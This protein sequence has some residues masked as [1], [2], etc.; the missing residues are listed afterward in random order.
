MIEKPTPGGLLDLQ[1]I[2]RW[3]VVIGLSVWAGV[4][5]FVRKLNDGQSRPFNF[6]E[7]IGEITVSGFT[8][9]LTAY[10][11]AAVG[12]HGPMQFAFAGVAAH[13]GS[14]W[15][16]KLESVLNQKFNL[17]T[18]APAPTQEKN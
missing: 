11:C 1:E 7:L 12:I 2:L 15:L 3:V 5:S 14:R 13:M 6:R 9:V 16:F 18:D 4:V 8:G 17:P 10:L